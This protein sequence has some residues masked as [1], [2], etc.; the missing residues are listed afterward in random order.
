[1]SEKRKSKDAKRMRY[2]RNAFKLVTETLASSKSLI[3]ITNSCDECA[4]SENMSLHTSLV[5][6]I[7]GNEFEH[8]NC[9]YDDSNSTRSL[10]KFEH[11]L[12]L[13][14]DLKNWSSKN[15]ISHLSLSELQI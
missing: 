10:S 5:A 15:N 6:E 13:A 9:L 7:F 1:M 8:R 12:S 3:D 2:K 11:E 14:A 4:S